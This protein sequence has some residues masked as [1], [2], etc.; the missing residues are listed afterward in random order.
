MTSRVLQVVRLSAH[1]FAQQQITSRWVTITVYIWMRGRVEASCVPEVVCVP[2]HLTHP[3]PYYLC[4]ELLRLQLRSNGSPISTKIVLRAALQQH[5][6]LAAR[7]A[8]A[9]QQAT[10]ASRF[11]PLSIG[12]QR[13]QLLVQQHQAQ[14]DAVSSR[15]AAWEAKVITLVNSCLLAP[16][17]QVCCCALLCICSGSVGCACAALTCM[18]LLQ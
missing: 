3:L 17:G 15:W 6:L 1:V 11:S 9:G 7:A 5:S 12:R 4:R 16:A 13:M 10:A 18:G 8:A 2:P 14:L